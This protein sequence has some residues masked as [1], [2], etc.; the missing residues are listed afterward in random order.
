[1]KIKISFTLL[2][3]IISNL[4]KAQITAD[5]T[6]GCAPMVVTF[7]TSLSG[8]YYWDFDNGATS[9]SQTPS[10]TFSTAKTYNVVLRSSVV[11]PILGTISIKVYDKPDFTLTTNIPP[12]GCTP[13]TLT[14]SL[15]PT[16]AL[17]AGIS[18]TNH[19]WVF[20]DLGGIP[21][22]TASESHT[23]SGL[24]GVYNVSVGI[25]TNLPSC[26]VTPSFPNFVSSSAPPTASFTANPSSACVAPV[27]ASFTNNSSSV[28]SNAGTLT[29]SWSFSDGAPTVTTTVP[30]PKTYSVS[31][32]YTV[33][34]TTTDANNCSNSTTRGI[35]IGSP[36][37]G[38][39][40]KDTVCI[41]TTT[42]F[43][44]TST[45]GFYSWVF[46]GGT[47]IPSSSAT[48]PTVSYSTP[49][50]HTISLTTTFPGG[51]D[52]T[53]IKTIYVEAPIATFTT[54]PTYSCS[55]PALF[56]FTGIS[57]NTNV[58]SWN[59]ILG[60]GTIKTG[61]S[62]SHVFSIPDSM[63]TE[64]GRK[65]FTSSVSITTNKG[66]VSPVYSGKDTIHLP[67]ARFMPNVA[68]GCA[69]LTVVFSDSS[70]SN[71]PITTWEWDYDDGTDTIIN[72]PAPL[73]HT[74]IFTTPGTY[75]V[76]LIITNSKGCKDTSYYI[77]IEVG[78]TKAGLDF[79]ADQLSVC[80][81]DVVNFTNTSSDKTG[82]DG[83]NFSSSGEFLSHC[84]Q[85]DDPSVV[86][87][88]L[89]GPQTITLTADYNGCLTSFTKANYIN[90][91]GPIAHFDYLQDCLTPFD[92]EFT[93]KSGGATTLSWDFGDGSPLSAATGT[94]VHTYTV[95]G[96]YKVILTA[97]GICGIS[98]DSTII[99]IKDIQAS[100]F[101]THTV[102]S[103]FC[104]GINYTFDASLSTDVFANCNRGY[105]WIFSDPAKR[106]ITYSSPISDTINFDSTNYQTI[107]LIVHD[108]NGCADT[109]IDTIKV[110]KV[111]AN[112]LISDNDIC[113]PALPVTFKD[114]SYADTTMV[115]WKWN[116]GDGTPLQLIQGPITHTYAP[117]ISFNTYLV[118]TDILGC[119]D[120][121]AKTITTYTPTST[122]TSPN[123]ASACVGVPVNFDATD[124]TS[125]GSNLTFKWNYNDGSPVAIGVP[126]THTFTS[127]ASPSTSYTVKLVY[128]E[129]IS[130]C[131]D[132]TTKI[133]TVQAYPVAGFTASNNSIFK[134][135]DDTVCFDNPIVNFNDTSAIGL[136]S[137]LP[138]TTTQW[139]F[140]TGSF[141]A[142]DLTSAAYNFPKGTHRVIMNSFTSF[143]CADRDTMT[144]HV[145]GPEGN[146][147]SPSN[148]CKGDAIT[149]KLT[150][151]DTADVG[152]YS[153]DFGD[154]TPFL[155]NTDPAT[156]TYG[157]IPGSGTFR[158]L[159]NL[160]GLNG[161][162]PTS[163]ERT[164]AVHDV[165]A[166]FSVNGDLD[167]AVCLGQSD[168]LVN[169]SSSLANSFVWDF[170]DGTPTFSTSSK[171]TIYH[172]YADTGS[173]NIE[174]SASNTTYGCPDDT[175][176]TV[177]VNALPVVVATGDT[178][179]KGNRVSLLSTNDPFY[180][181]AWTPNGELNN[182]T[183]Y[184]PNLEG[185]L[186]QTFTVTVTDS[187]T[188]ANSATAF[189]YVVQPLTD[190]YFD[191]SIV[192]GDYINLPITKQNDMVKFTWTPETGLS[193]IDCAYP[194]IQPME[195]IVYTALMKDTCTEATGTF[196]IH[197]RPE[198]FIQLPTTFTPNGDGANDIIYVKGWGIK[199][200]ISFEIYN[201]WGELIF[202]TSELS[203]GWNGYYK[204]I[205]QNN[206]TYVWKVKALTWRDTTLAK[207][208]HF[209]L[210]R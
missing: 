29:Y 200:L 169:L 160:S 164:I 172:T 78:A 33:S 24:G 107:G 210:M 86:F 79:T 91:Q 119:T 118:V 60:D 197:V 35:S 191:T 10:T 113:F 13:L 75:S 158:V 39:M 161:V 149:L 9:P 186:S 190:I 74:H 180:I 69:P 205:L 8:P 111:K 121:I 159:L 88:D 22:G 14:F 155:V 98:K 62:F 41:N 174:L 31:G 123:P 177:S 207:E 58:V 4:I 108:I 90:V 87:N 209:N 49:G 120:S 81:G 50:N 106:P 36:V 137:A 72:A 18:I 163:K 139:D 105:S 94:F 203:E 187:N 37:A 104:K 54:S 48:N 21:L 150:E 71:E 126:V 176:Q 208:G 52:S 185:S 148:I 130:G 184:N 28:S 178:I 145:V 154:G 20:G 166:D 135:D 55:E 44:N 188:C 202:T 153:W 171:S 3:L 204:G 5:V 144:L 93:D 182:A 43:T 157:Y 175:T 84:F 167:S 179:C 97:S 1:M 26:N 206:D 34:L 146:F 65:I 70:H 189:L 77:V 25:T 101:T 199:D 192:V 173:Y 46:D 181:Y 59:W 125:H 115:N 142:G 57:S 73:T 38:F 95:T 12:V 198:M 16:P 138:L 183:V 195:D 40:A 114:T 80:P 82:V 102:D 61:Q 92:V 109:L 194:Q 132:S 140:G 89:V 30:A 68:K 100:F 53:I 99:Y 15:T 193:C 165:R 17:P 76:S 32:N 131:K 51:C 156:H 128:T 45:P 85:D 133:V 196:I 64:R 201:R 141:S 103:L 147:T 134:Q 23:Y 96:N 6:E 136:T 122:I 83:W 151:A 7:S 63:Y 19:S 47:S 110:F 168:T 124:F 2:I 152:S 127:S 116:F 67:W 129:N 162:C 112:Y 42:T 27:T 117:G 66:C 170:G 143:G 11:G 56:N